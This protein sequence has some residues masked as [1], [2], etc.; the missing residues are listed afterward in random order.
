MGKCDITVSRLGYIRLFYSRLHGL[1]DNEIT[2]A[3]LGLPT[4]L[5]AIL[6]YASWWGRT[7]HYCFQARLGYS[8]YSRLGS[9][10]LANAAILFPEFA[11][12][13]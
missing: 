12:P 11:R 6:S 8:G 1:G 10:V 5:W 7:R 3:R 2:V 4:L 9:L 13:L